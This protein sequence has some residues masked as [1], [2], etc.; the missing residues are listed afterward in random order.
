MFSIRNLVTQSKGNW[1]LSYAIS[2]WFCRN[3]MVIWGKMDSNNKVTWPWENILY[4]CNACS[5]QVTTERSFKEHVVTCHGDYELY[6]SLHGKQNSSLFLC[7]W[8]Q[9]YIKNSRNNVTVH[10][11]EQ[12]GSTLLQYEKE[13][14]FGR[15]LTKGVVQQIKQGHCPNLIIVKVYNKW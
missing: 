12:H 14:G 11:N 4:S 10:C 13:F 9:N 6:Q 5:Y 8:C 15:V 1:N 3:L 2:R 7:Q